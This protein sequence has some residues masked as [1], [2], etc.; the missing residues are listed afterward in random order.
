[1]LVESWIYTLGQLY[2]SLTTDNYY[3]KFLV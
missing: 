3:V 2:D 1:M